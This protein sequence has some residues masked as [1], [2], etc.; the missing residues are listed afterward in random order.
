MSKF[1]VTGGAGFIGL[2]LVHNLCAS[3]EKV[4]I[5]DDFSTSKKKYL[6]DLPKDVKVV[7]GDVL[8]LKEV[9]KSARTA[10]YV[11]HL[12][13]QCSVLKSVKDPGGTLERN[14]MGTLSAL[15]AAQDAVALGVPIVFVIEAENRR[16]EWRG[17]L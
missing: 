11:V 7:E 14:A 15:L 12:A 16:L 5:L 2:N 6:R 13:G 4:V 8:D 1:L 9:K 3:G 10:D 17:Q